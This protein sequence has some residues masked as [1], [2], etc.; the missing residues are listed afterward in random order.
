LDNLS[1]HK[2]Q[3][4]GQL[5]S[6]REVGLCFL[7]PYSPDLNPIEQ[8]FAKLK[9]LLRQAAARSLE[10]LNNA[11]AA[12]LKSFSAQHCQGFIRHAQYAST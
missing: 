7:P 3:N 11:L 12:A 10:D 6:A 5:L 8:A 9:A 4:A 1:T 2:I